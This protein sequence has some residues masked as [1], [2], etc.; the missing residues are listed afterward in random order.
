M[1]ARD[2]FRDW[3]ESDLDQVRVKLGYLVH[4]KTI[5]HEEFKTM[6]GM[7]DSPDKENKI[8]AEEIISTMMNKDEH[9]ELF[10]KEGGS[11]K[12]YKASLVETSTGF[13]VSFAYGRRGNT[14]TNG[15]KTPSPVPYDKAKK[16]YDKLVQE[17]TSKG[18]TPEEGAKPFTGVADVVSRDTGFRPQLLNDI[19]EDT[20]EKYITDPEWCAQEKYDGVRRGIIREGNVITA[21]NRKGLSVPLDKDMEKYLLGCTL[22]GNFV[23]DG[24]QVG[25]VFH[26]FDQPDWDYPFMQRYKNLKTTFDFSGSYV[27]IVST[28]W[29]EDQKRAM[30]KML[31]KNNAEG[32]VFKK[33]DAKYKPGRP[34]KG[35][36]QIKFKFYSTASCIVT[37]GKSDK[38]SISLAVLVD[39]TD[40]TVPV[41]N[42][43]VYPNQKR[44]EKGTIVEVRYLYY[45]MNGSLFQPVLL[46]ERTDIDIEDC[47]LS[48]LKVKREEV[49]P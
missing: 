21:T 4:D 17:K 22:H 34:S 33:I 9:I 40:E 28:A 36:D 6:N 15:T 5:S 29:T 39:G 26:V 44:P 16:I 20:V 38:N 8:V 19:E 11:D 42:V 12:V 27:K 32:I 23:L 46:G 48:K 47:T 14:L 24:E 18:Y 1:S 49:E 37:G 45:F 43:T 7:I 35:G 13:T 30:L 25:D 10:F 41:G 3:E 2:P 31:R